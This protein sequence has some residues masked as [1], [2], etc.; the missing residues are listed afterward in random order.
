MRELS[1]YLSIVE[2]KNKILGEKLLLNSF[3]LVASNSEIERLKN[4]YKFK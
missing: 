4:C 2:N 1:E 3:R